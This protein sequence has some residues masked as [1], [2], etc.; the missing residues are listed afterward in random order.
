M[1]T[2]KGIF[3]RKQEGQSH[4]EFIKRFHDINTHIKE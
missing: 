3:Q 2:I 4:D 1:P